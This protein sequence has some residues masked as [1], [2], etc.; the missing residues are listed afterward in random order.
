MRPGG[1]AVE[2]TG[3]SGNIGGGTEAAETEGGNLNTEFWNWG[4]KGEAAGRKGEAG[5][6]MGVKCG[7]KGS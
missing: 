2:W 4:G 7:E 1:E 6:R 5:S 3:R